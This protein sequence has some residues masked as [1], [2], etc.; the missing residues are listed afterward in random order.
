[1]QSIGDPIDCDFGIQSSYQIDNF[2]FIMSTFSRGVKETFLLSV[3]GFLSFFQSLCFSFSFF[4][5]EEMERGPS[6][7]FL[8]G[9]VGFL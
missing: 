8:G 2:C 1:M 6:E 3:G 5:L 7:R 4:S 9:K